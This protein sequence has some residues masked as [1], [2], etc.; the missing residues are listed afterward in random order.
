[1]EEKMGCKVLVIDD[2]IYCLDVS[3]EYLLD[4]KF[5][6]SSSH[7]PVCPLIR[8]NAETCPMT[9]PCYDFVLS[10]NHMPQMTGLEF[11]TYQTQ[12]GCKIP[13]QRKALISGDISEKEAA[14]AKKLG[15]TV[16]RKPCSFN[17]LDHWINNLY[18][19]EA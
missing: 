16:F 13:P 17:T 9:T 14:A 4:K 5:T 7:E 8:T 1:M 12:R 11:F 18:P 3:V 2:D 19:M 10:D 15:C 6:V